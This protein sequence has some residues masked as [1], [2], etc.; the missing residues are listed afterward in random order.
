MFKIRTGRSWKNGRGWFTI[1]DMKKKPTK[2]DS[3]GDA[4]F[5]RVEAGGH[6]AL[7]RWSRERGELPAFLRREDEHWARALSQRVAAMQRDVEDF[8]KSEGEIFEHECG[9]ALAAAGELNGVVFDE[10]A[11]NLQNRANDPEFDL[12]ARNGRLTLVGEAKRTLRV[13]DVR[14]FAELRLPMFAK[15]HPDWTRG[16][17][18]VGALFFKRAVANKARR[19]ASAAERDPVALAHSLGLLAVQATGKSGLRVI[20]PER[21]R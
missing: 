15:F 20:A 16:R 9:A 6:G 4:G 3:D 11:C 12:A 1:S 10:V 13:D 18:V 2:S 5:R 17:K 14:H 19:G 8:V 7:S 21:G